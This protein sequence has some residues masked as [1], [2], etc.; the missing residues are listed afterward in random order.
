MSKSSLCIAFHS[1][2]NLI[3][4]LHVERVPSQHFLWQFISAWTIYYP[5]SLWWRLHRMQFA[6]W[7][8]W[9]YVT[10]A[11]E[12]SYLMSLFQPRMSSEGIFVN[13][14]ELALKTLD[15]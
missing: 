12:F 14:I 4:S 15:S 9:K 7:L 5:F 10:L 1:E 8:A 2:L 3:I 6:V 13:S 11:M